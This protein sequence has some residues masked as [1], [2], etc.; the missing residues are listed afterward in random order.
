LI[1][2]AQNPF[3]FFSKQILSRWRQ[4]RRQAN[5]RVVSN[6]SSIKISA[7]SL[8]LSALA[9]ITNQSARRNKNL[10][11]VLLLIVVCWGSARRRRDIGAGQTTKRERRVDVEREWQ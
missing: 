9:E 2:T 7:P 5:K 8:S 10:L 11:W 3:L 1:S 4:S 6:F